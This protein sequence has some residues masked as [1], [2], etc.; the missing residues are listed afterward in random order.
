MVRPL[1]VRVTGNSASYMVP[2]SVTS[3]TVTEAGQLSIKSS[4]TLPVR[5]ITRVSVTDLPAVLVS[6]KVS[7]LSPGVRVC[8][9]LQFTDLPAGAASTWA[10]FTVRVAR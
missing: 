4:G 7:V 3:G 1:M 10:P 5:R 9:L 2:R 8:R 6:T